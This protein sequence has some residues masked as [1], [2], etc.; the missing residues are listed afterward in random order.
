MK[1]G[2]LEVY[3]IIYKITN[4][5]NR[6][7]Y[8]GQTMKDNGFNSRYNRKGEG[9]ERVYRRQKTLRDRGFGYNPHLLSAIEKYGFEA[10][11]I[12]EILDIAFSKSE[13]NIKEKS[14][15]LICN[16]FKNGYNRTLGGEGV[17]GFKGLSKENNPASRSVV[18]LSLE[19]EFIKVWDC[20]TY[21]YESLGIG[22]SHICSV[23]NN[24]Y[25]RK[26]TGGYLWVYLEDYMPD[27]KY[28]HSIDNSSVKKSIVKL[29]F[30]GVYISSYS[31]IQEA[32]NEDNS[33]NIKGISRCCNGE[34]K[35]YKGYL[36]IF[37][38]NY[39]KNYN[40][41][42]D[43]KSSGKSKLILAFD[44]NMKLIGEYKSHKEVA[45]TFGYS[46]SS[47]QNHLTGKANKIKNHIFIY[48]EKYKDKVS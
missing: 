27:K 9:I 30:D 22:I 24:K 31:S 16:S 35:S 7:V 15:I 10:F 4:K 47:L 48:K 41:E 12:V 5:I 43:S 36:W 38:D 13:L 21:V 46:R 32:V 20:I 8:I 11:D 40:Y 6:K 2:N 39:N 3:G 44:K 17:S 29:S 19:G 26:S 45:E 1:M 23:C 37:K 28:I 33:L 18:Q 14:W 25:G 34:R 42:Y